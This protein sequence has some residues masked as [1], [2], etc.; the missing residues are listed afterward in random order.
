MQTHRQMEARRTSYLL[1]ILFRLLLII[2]LTTTS[3]IGAFF[4]IAIALERAMQ[5][6]QLRD[7]IRQFNKRRL[8]PLT[9]KIAGDSSGTYAAL[10]HVG[11][12]SG[13][14]YQTPVVAELLDDGFV[15]PLPY[16]AN[17]DWCRNVM[18]AG[19]CTL[20]WNEHEYTLDQP[21]LLPREAA[22][23]GFPWAQ[24]FIFTS[25]GIKQFLWLRKHV[26][27][28]EKVLTGS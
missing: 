21:K 3:I 7:R 17:V 28:S 10:K 16:G 20:R 11:R 19:G 1:Q 24:R 26:E 25:G 6:P 2:I 5:Q 27:V 15:I 14:T 4:L 9:L 8:N 22:L 23:R 12:R 13:R 18:A